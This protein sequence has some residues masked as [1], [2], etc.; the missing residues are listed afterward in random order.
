MA[1]FSKYFKTLMNHEGG[2][3][4]DPHDHG[5]ATKYGITLGTWLSKGYDKNKD[6]KVNVEDLKLISVD[7][8]EKI[9]KKD[10]WDTVKGDDINSQSIAEFVFDWGY[11][12]GPR[13]A[14][15]KLQQVLGVEEDGTIGNRTIS[16]LN[17][18][19]QR[20][21][22]DKLVSSRLAFVENIVK[23]DSSQAKFLK[24]WKN[25]INSFKF[26]D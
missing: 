26:L 10:Y 6:G 12:S 25:R 24:G 15:K 9:A 17:S 3:V 8:A 23:N 1:D 20:E 7:D 14:I 11:N 18:S 2:F 13:T 16:A 19:V 5:G 21:T 4:D 22:F